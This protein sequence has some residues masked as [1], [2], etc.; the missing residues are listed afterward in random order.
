VWLDPFADPT[1]ASF[2]VV[3]SLYGLAAGGLLGTGLG[4][5]NPQFVP[6]AKTDFII[7]TAGEELGLAG[8]FAIL[9][10]YAILVQRGFRTGVAAR[11][12]FGTLLAG[13]LAIVIAL[14]VFVVV[15]GV[16]RLIPLT[17]LTMPFMSYGGS[18]LVAN[19]MIIALLLRIS[20][21]ARRPA[22]EPAANRDD[23]MT[24]VVRL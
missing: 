19:W 15:G 11:D 6:F 13:G 8:L 9:T 2:Q 20:D 3:Q 14:Q 12:A 23:A 16:T 7:A 5:G 1:G 10:V 17:G 22:P 21:V 18:S 4:L 24:Q